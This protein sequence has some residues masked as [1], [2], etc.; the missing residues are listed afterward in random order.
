MFYVFCCFGVINYNNLCTKLTD[1]VDV[2]A[3]DQGDYT[4]LNAAGI[5][6]VRS[7]R[8]LPGTSNSE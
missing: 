6:S 2:I 1:Y 3:A 8:A 7:A 5:L 4:A